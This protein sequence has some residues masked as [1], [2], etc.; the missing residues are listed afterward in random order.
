LD[1][2]EVAIGSVEIIGVAEG[3]NFAGYELLF[4]PGAQPGAGDWRAVGNPG[5]DP[6]PGDTL[7]VWDTTGL[8]PG[9]YTLLLRAYDGD[10]NTQTAQV[11]VQ[12]VGE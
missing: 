1:G 6:V 3:P 5:L 7:G 4:A 11:R 8:E 12:V 9:T 2:A 10:G